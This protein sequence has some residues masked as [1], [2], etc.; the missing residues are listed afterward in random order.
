MSRRRKAF[1]RHR[2]GQIKTGYHGPRLNPV[3]F[4]DLKT[5][6]KA[7]ARTLYRIASIS[8][9]FTAV[10]ILQLHEKDKLKLND[11]ISKYLPWFKGKN[12][13]GDLK[14]ITIRQILSHTSGLFR[15]GE[16]PHWDTDKFPRTL[17]GTFSPR[18]LIIKNSTKFK[19]SNHALSV[20]GEIIEKASGQDYGNYM[21]KNILRKLGMSDTYPDL[22]PKALPNLATG[23]GRVFP[24]KKEQPIFKHSKTYADAPATGFISNVPDLGKFL[25]ALTLK[26]GGKPS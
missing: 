5:E 15:D 19:Y 21:R 24:R 11:P 26:R 10:A 14:N 17:K 9:M 23:Y 1:W 7:T 25:T 8:K 3:G 12:K 4:A 13:N 20:L 16:S 18:S 2:I 22:V 6:K